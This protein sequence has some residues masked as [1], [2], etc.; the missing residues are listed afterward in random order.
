MLENGRILLNNKK[1]DHNNLDSTLVK[2]GDKVLFKATYHI[3]P[4]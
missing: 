2:K 1:I 3:E 4:P